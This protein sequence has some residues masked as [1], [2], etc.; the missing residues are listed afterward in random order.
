ML[1]CGCEAGQG[2]N[3]GPM[4]ELGLGT[5]W[6]G[7]EWRVKCESELGLPLGSHSLVRVGGDTVSG[8]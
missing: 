2:Q 5:A 6:H 3:L 7:E 8:L 4:K 1:T